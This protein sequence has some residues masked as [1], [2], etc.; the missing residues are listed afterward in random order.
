[1]T[2]PVKAKAK[3]DAA[4][5]RVADQVKNILAWLKRRGTKK[6]RDGMARFAI[7]APRAF[8][9]S[10]ATMK[11]LV[12]RTERNH[13][14][15]LKLWASGWH[16]ARML[17]SLLDEPARVT[18]AQM[19]AWAKSFNNWADCD[20]A[21]FALFDRTPHGFKKVAQ[22]SRRDEEFVKRGAFALLASLAL[23]DRKADDAAFLRCLPMIE[24]AATDDRNFVRKGVNWALRAIGERNSALNALAVKL[25]ERLAASDMPSAR[26]IGKDALRQLKSPAATK[27]LAMRDKRNAKKA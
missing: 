25:A 22:W 1:M 3:K 18:P 21:C 24:A 6:N 26:W 16:E 15:A 10:M 19:D 8:G 23:H 12:K 7:V 14:L 5:L 13:D 9:V 4:P 27:R 2:I 11:C 17:A 20:T